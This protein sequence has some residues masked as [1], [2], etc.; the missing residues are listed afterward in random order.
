MRVLVPLPKVYKP[1][2]TRLVTG[3]KLCWWC[4]FSEHFLVPGSIF[5]LPWW[6]QYLAGVLP[7]T[8]L[9]LLTMTLS[10]DF[11]RPHLS[12]DSSSSWK[13]NCQTCITYFNHTLVMKRPQNSFPLVSSFIC[14]SP[15]SSA[16]TH[17]S[18]ILLMINVIRRWQPLPLFRNNV[19]SDSSP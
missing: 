16:Q 14:L 18:F 9:P 12:L 8:I 15:G 2:K 5:E 17:L 3:S 11:H 19:H 13:H 7:A 10:L 4:F 6:C 1:M